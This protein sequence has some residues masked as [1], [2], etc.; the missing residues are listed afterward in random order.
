MKLFSS[1]FLMVLFFGCGE[2]EKSAEEKQKERKEQQIAKLASDPK[3]AQLIGKLKRIS[4][5]PESPAIKETRT[6]KDDLVDQLVERELNDK[7]FPTTKTS[8]SFD[9]KEN[10]TSKTTTTY[11]YADTGFANTVAIQEEESISYDGGEEKNKIVTRQEYTY[12]PEKGLPAWSPS[13]IIFYKDEEKT[14]EVSISCNIEELSCDSVTID[15]DEK[16]K[17]ETETV[18]ALYSGEILGIPEKRVSIENSYSITDTATFAEETFSGYSISGQ[19]KAFDKLPNGGKALQVEGGCT[20]EEDILTCNVDFTY[21]DKVYRN[22]VEKSLMVLA[23]LHD[24]MI[25][26]LLPLEK[27]DTNFSGGNPESAS[28]SKYN[29]EY[30][31]QLRLIK[32]TFT[33]S[34]GQKEVTEI[35]YVEASNQKAEE[36][37]TDSEGELKYKKVFEYKS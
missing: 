30:D 13:S 32:E 11:Q 23:E 3:F 20:I 21:E 5:T 22:E 9:K 4:L 12:D 31:E 6:N 36:T 34:Q 27:S 8:Q 33:D 2:D 24:R 14:Y 16:G 19:V 37:K 1:V 29:Y 17:K 28:N 35:K 15:Y 7:G 26:H 25:F 10:L 18:Q